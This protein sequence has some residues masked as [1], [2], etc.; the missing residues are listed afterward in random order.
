MIFRKLSQKKI[1]TSL[2]IGLFIFEQ[3]SYSI[4]FAAINQSSPLILNNKA[5]K[6]SAPEKDKDKIRGLSGKDY[7]SGQIIVKYKKNKNKTLFST[8]NKVTT[9]KTLKDKNSRLL[10]INDPK[11]MSKWLKQ[12]KSD[13]NVDYA[14]PNYIRKATFIPNDSRFNEQWSLSKMQVIN[15]WDNVVVNPAIKVAII[16][17]GVDTNHEDL[18]GNIISGINYI[19]PGSQ[20]EDNNGHGTHVAGIIAATS[21]NGVGITGIASGVKI[22]PIKVLDANGYGSDNNVGDGI[23][24]AA[25]NGANIIN[26]SLGGPEDSQYI[27]DAINYAHNKGV[28]VIAAAGNENSSVGYPAAN[29]H[30]IAVA[31]TDSNDNKPSFSNYGPEVDVA[32]PGVNILSTVPNTQVNPYIPLN[33]ASFS[34]TSMAA[35]NVTGVAALILSKYPNITPFQLETRLKSTSQDLGNPG[36]DTY[37]GFGRVNALQAITTLRDNIPSDMYEPN[38]SLETAK[39]I[40]I[41]SPI[42]GSFSTP[43]DSDWYK[44]SLPKK[45]NLSLNIP[46]N[47]DGIMEIYSLNGQLV[48]TINSGG[49]GGSETQDFTIPSDGIYYIKIK[50]ATGKTSL[51]GYRL[52]VNE[53][54]IY[55]PNNTIQTASLIP[56]NQTIK[57]KINPSNDLDYYKIV[58]SQGGATS[59]NLTPPALMDGV[60]TLYSTN[61]N[62][63]NSADNAS[64]GGREVL[65]K[66]LPRGT[67]YIK[68]TDY[69]GMSYNENYSLNVNFQPDI[70]P[71]TLTTTYPNNNGI[72]VPINPTIVL[73]F[74][75]DIV[76]SNNFD[77][78]TL[79]NNK[80]V[81][82]PFTKTILNNKITLI[83]TVPLDYGTVYNVNIPSGAVKDI[84]WNDYQGSTLTFTTIDPPRIISTEPISNTQQIPVNKTISITFSENIYASNSFNNIQLKA[85]DGSISDCDL[86]IVE[87]KLVISPKTV[88]SLNKTYV[89][90]IPAGAVKDIY[91]N[92]LIQPYNLSFSIGLNL[93]AIG[94]LSINNDASATNN[95]LVNLAINIPN[96]SNFIQEMSLSND[97]Q[98]WSNWETISSSN[99]LELQSGDS[100]K[101]VFAKFRDTAGSQSS[102][103]SDSIILD[104]VNP[105]A[106]LIIN[107]D[108]AYTNNKTVNLNINGT[109]TNEIKSMSISN[110][111]QDWGN[112]E[113]YNSNK[114][115]ILPNENSNNNVYI[116]VMDEAGNESSIASDTIFLD[117]Q[118]PTGSVLINN[119]DLFVNTDLVD[120]KLI[121]IDNTE[122]KEMSISSDGSTWSNWQPYTPNNQWKLSSASET[123]FVYVK[124]RDT[125]GNESLIYSDFIDLDTTKPTG[126]ITINDNSTF[127]NNTSV[128]LSL[129]TS[130]P[131][132]LKDISFSN[133]NINWIEWE[134]IATNKQWELPTGDGEKSVF[135]RI[136]DMAGNISDVYSDNI[137]LDETPPNAPTIMT[138]LISTQSSNKR[139]FNIQWKG[140]DISAPGYPGSGINSY[141]IQYRLAGSSKWIDWA[142]DIKTTK[143]TFTGSRGS[144]YYF[145]ARTKDNALKVGKWSTV[146]YKT[147]IPYDD[148]DLVVANK[149]FKSTL[150]TY[151]FLG[152]LKYS[153]K[154]N[155]TI[156]YK[157]TG[158]SVNLITT[159]GPGRGKA[160]IYIDN[161]YKTTIDTYSSTTKYR[162]SLYST[163]FSKTGTHTIKIVNLG[164]RRRSR[165]DIDGLT[166]G[167]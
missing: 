104:T 2:L 150:G 15:A 82:V 13:P 142:K 158:N 117:T 155:D 105:A 99:T 8:V 159:K 102:I 108:S 30:V 152:T 122:V 39:I 67:Y 6:K 73:N 91:G 115:W 125:A 107:N 136:R 138:P 118:K 11:E 37:Y 57:A 81:N 62:Y 87:N 49:V 88:F 61:G 27:Q 47:V 135:F 40:N 60:I 124:F 36:F 144:T 90:S 52:R 111:G 94:T 23:R 74:S 161:V 25:D 140:N 42:E 126:S 63:I 89:L 120:L 20:P 44:I 113:P 116:K 72:E 128:T 53:L 92:N 166:V 112:W 14:I 85:D 119:G 109:D 154:V 59:I 38:D 132:G 65:F 110:N 1:L 103:I 50:E 93:G 48:N 34:G 83:P 151:N 160:K 163:K 12:F 162:Q 156:T 69:W 146:V 100:V 28:I 127:T 18:M 22:M 68:I 167:K 79:R 5:I 80:N 129:T 31:A 9:L 7:V 35:P 134:P 153:L 157:F 41:N 66:N 45:V 17:T 70:I 54:D 97:G 121:A 101:T 149:G 145:R 137:I 43:A 76:P 75:E 21:N 141:D 33:Y 71:P 24:W 165:V 133:D 64:D 55:E 86:A 139:T 58:L 19:Q 106:T 95:P 32:A 130:D 143:G 16:D 123:G 96:M 4:A 147:T 84:V 3:L 77:N 29:D 46:S 164:T 51:D 131:Q 26:L 78:I 98:T 56:V 10:E 148:N 114:S